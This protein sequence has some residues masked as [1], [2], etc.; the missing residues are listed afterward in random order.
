M[1][2]DERTM[3]TTGLRNLGG[4]LG[5]LSSP[6]YQESSIQGVSVLAKHLF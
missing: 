5:H 6:Q 3:Y 1:R 2:P 4:R